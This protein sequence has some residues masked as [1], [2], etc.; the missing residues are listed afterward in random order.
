V[1][2]NF[3]GRPASPETSN[4]NAIFINKPVAAFKATRAERNYASEIHQ[5]T[6]FR[7]DAVSMLR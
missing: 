3:V 6:K 4:T 7:I 2:G 5:K 1:R